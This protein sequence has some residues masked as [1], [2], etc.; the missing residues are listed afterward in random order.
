MT[1]RQCVKCGRELK[2]K[3]HLL[4]PSCLNEAKDVAM[5]VGAAVATVASVAITIL[6]RGAKGKR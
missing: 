6:I 3:E 4:C 1:T 2:Q 5:K